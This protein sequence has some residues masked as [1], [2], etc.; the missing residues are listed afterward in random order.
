MVL[1]LATDFTCLIK[2]A[3]QLWFEATPITPMDSFGATANLRMMKKCIRTYTTNFFNLPS[4][5]WSPKVSP[6][7]TYIVR[8]VMHAGFLVSK[9]IGFLAGSQHLMTLLR[10]IYHAKQRFPSI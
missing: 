10:S 7:K 4:Y 2:S 9:Y 8:V 1:R 3:T 5:N 6:K